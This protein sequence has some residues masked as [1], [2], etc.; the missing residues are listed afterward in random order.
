M[1]RTKAG[2][3]KKIFLGIGVGSL[4][5]SSYKLEFGLA[6]LPSLIISYIFQEIENGKR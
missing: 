3:L 2:V 1:A 5:A 6:A 4:I